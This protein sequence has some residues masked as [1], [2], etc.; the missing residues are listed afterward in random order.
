MEMQIK[1]FFV[2]LIRSVALWSEDWSCRKGSNRYREWRDPESG[3]W[4]SE[5]TAMKLMLCRAKEKA[6]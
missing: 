5:S 1:F 4:F 3:L 2:R 6:I